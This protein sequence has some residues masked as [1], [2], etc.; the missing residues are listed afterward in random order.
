MEDE[1]DDDQLCPICFDHWKGT[2]THRIVSLKCGHLFG[3]SCVE[4]WVRKNKKCPK[5]NQP[6]K[7]T[8]VR[9]IFA[10]TIKVKE[11]PEEERLMAELKKALE[12]FSSVNLNPEFSIYFFLN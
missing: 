10:P 7:L 8:D 12:V 11:A 3:K 4:K 1:D 5:C 2:G 6:N 9:Q